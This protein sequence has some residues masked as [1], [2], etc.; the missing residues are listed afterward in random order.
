MRNWFWLASSLA[1]AATAGAQGLLPARVEIEYELKR[2]GS[3]MAEVT[4]VLEQANGRYR[5]S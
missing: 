3:T 1:L 4:D 5:L 2:N